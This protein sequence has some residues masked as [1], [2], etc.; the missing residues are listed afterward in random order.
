MPFGWFYRIALRLWLLGLPCLGY[1]APDDDAAFTNPSLRAY[2]LEEVWAKVGERSCLKCHHPA[3]DAEDSRFILKDPMRLPAAERPAAHRANHKIFARMAGMKKKGKSLLLQKAVGELEHEGEQVVKPGSTGYRILEWFLLSPPPSYTPDYSPPPYFSDIEMLSAARLLRR[4]SLSLVGRL[5]TPGESRLVADR[6]MDGLMQVLDGMMRDD[7]FYDRLSEG[8]ND[9]FLLMGQDGVAERIAG[10][11]NFGDTRM[12]YQ[13]RK[14][15]HI[16]DEK[17]RKRAGWSLADDYRV[18]ILR[19]PFELIDYIVRNERPFTELVT[20]DY[21]MVSPYTA[22]GYGIFEE[23]KERFKDPEDFLEF[24]PARLK[25]LTLRTGKPDQVTPTGMYPHAGLLTTFHYLQRYPTTDTNRN[26][27]R[28]RKFYEHFLGI[29]LM[30]LAPRVTDAAAVDAKYAIPTMEAPDCVVCHRLVDPVAGLFRDYQ[31]TSNDN[32]P[33]GPREEGWFTDMFG[34]GFEGEDLP[35]ADRWRSLQWLGRI[36]AKDPR[37]AIAMVEHVYYILTGRKVLPA[38]E[39]IEDPLFGSRRRAYQEQRRWIEAIARDFAGNNFNLKVV[40]KDLV[41]SPFYRADGLSTVATHPRRQ[42]E[43]DDL[44]V[45]HLLTPEQLGRKIS[46]IFGEPWGRFNDQ[47]KILYGGIDSRAVTE[48]LQDPSGAMGAVQRIL[49]NDVACKH[50]ARDFAL[51]ASERILFPGIEVDV[52]PG[53]N[54]AADENIRRAIVHL[55][56]RILGRMDAVG[57]PEVERAFHLFDGIVRE[58]QARGRDKIA[59]IESY[60]CKSSG[61]DGPRDKDPHYTIRA[62]RA[63][64]TYL[65][66][67]HEFLYE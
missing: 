6:D 39:D 8:F 13:K 9:I 28:T 5:P 24:V 34:P 7:A 15:E 60:H 47:L 10:Y 26:R 4:V 51:P 22:R 54:E 67:Q 27:L 3:G 48:R 61:Q 43:L 44:G 17:A 53:A 20:A 37:F 62:W 11:R 66:R 14:F 56:E 19:E 42:A 52:V 18:S 29:D 50:V 64:V 49:S 45:V 63:V 59:P 58:A 32:G 1:S 55:H 46:A 30:A 23:L 16:E 38:P 65:L 41:R 2:F 40:F 12:W 31:N 36:T 25:A 35:E 57:D 21:I 33:Y